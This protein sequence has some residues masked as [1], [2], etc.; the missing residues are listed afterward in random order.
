MGITNFNK[1]LKE[2][3]PHVFETVCMSKFSGKKIALDSQL[4]LYKFKCANPDRWKNSAVHFLLEFRK[5]NVHPLMVFEGKGPQAKSKTVQKRIETSK[6]SMRR[7]DILKDLL[8]SPSSQHNTVL[9]DELKT[10][11]Q[12]L[13]SLKPFMFGGMRTETTIEGETITSSGGDESVFDDDKLQYEIEKMEKRC[14]RITE[15]DKNTF[16][17]ICECLGITRVDAPGESEEYCCALVKSGYADAVLSDDSDCM[18]YGANV[19]LSKMDSKTKPT[20][21][22]MLKIEELYSELGF[23]ADEFTKFCCLCGTD[24][25]DNPP[26]MGPVKILA[27][28]KKNGNSFDHLWDQKYITPYNIFIGNRK[29]APMNFCRHPTKKMLTYLTQRIPDISIDMDKMFECSRSTPVI[30]KEVMDGMMSMKI[31]DVKEEEETATVN[32]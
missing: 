25:E 1:F 20:T 22:S 9:L 30:M 26:G 24:Y 8:I 32:I 10:L 14:I 3:Y 12:D 4:F 29:V 28:I 31:Q 15:F 11:G 27:S 16:R 6:K 5:H 17:V 13:N 2:K 21:F 19:W 18:A 7:L 23:T